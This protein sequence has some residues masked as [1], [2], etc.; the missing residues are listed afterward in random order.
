LLLE[1]ATRTAN[2]LAAR[3]KTAPFPVMKDLETYDFSAMP[4]LSKQKILEW[5]RG[6]WIDQNTNACFIGNAGIGKTHLSV[7]RARPPAG[8]ANACDSSPPPRGSTNGK[9]HKNS[10]VWNG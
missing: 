9:K 4:S 1:V 10:T 7:R 3:I 8:S 6:Q 2:A 5:A